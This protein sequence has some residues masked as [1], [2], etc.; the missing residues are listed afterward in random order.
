VTEATRGEREAAA[1]RLDLDRAEALERQYDS[2]MS[3]RPLPA[4]VMGVVSAGLVA[5][6]A[7]HYYTAGFGILLEHWHMAVHLAAVLAACFLVF[8]HNARAKRG[9]PGRFAFGG[10]PAF[11]W[12]LVFL[13]VGVVIYLPW[14]FDELTFRIGIPNTTDQVMGWVLVALVLE[15]TRRAMGWILPAIVV[16]FIAYGL[17]GQVL[18]GT[19]FD[20]L[21]HPGATTSN[22]IS[23][24]YLTQEGIFGIPV[25]VVSTYVFHFVLFG[26]LAMRMG[27]GQFF[28]DLSTIAAGRLA[29]GPAKVSIFGSA[30]FGMIS[31]SSL[32]NAVTVGSLT[33][34][35]MKRVGYK[36]HFAGA[37]E[38][39]A[40]AGGQITPPIM[41]AVA[42]IMVEFLQIPYT[43]IIIAAAVPAAMHY[44]GVLVQVHFEAKKTG[45]K[46]LPDSE[47]PRFWPTLRDGWPTTIPM[48]LLI[49][50]IMDGSTPYLAAFRG[51]TACLVV[52]LL[53]PNKAKRMTLSQVWV[54]F[55]VGA[56]YAL[57]VGCAAAATGVVVGVITLTGAGFRVSFM[58]TTAAANAANFVQPILALLPFHVA[59]AA[60]LKLFF[61]LVCVAFASILLGTGLPTTAV[62]ILLA[63]IT[64][65]A[66]TN[67]GVPPLAAHL[68]IF[69]YG[70]LAD[71]TPPVCVAA[72]AAA[73]IAG[74][75]PFKTGNT[76]FKLGTAKAT[77]PFVFV[78]APSML[79]VLPG[80]TWFDF[81]VS[82]MACALGIAGLGIAMTGYFLAPLG[83]LSR[84]WLTLASLLT[85]AP[86]VTSTA[87]GLAMAAPVIGL[88]LLRARGTAVPAQPR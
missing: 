77:V 29:G 69:Y 45:L 19:W 15:S 18:T 39:A 73:G 25:K 78:Y 83:M 52:G 24:V 43:Q 48:I 22:L 82:T 88:N 37:V 79:L 23:H 44:L 80:F 55:D 68:F 35:A 59:S 72:F 74:A 34:P 30:L 2:E 60:D 46:G 16:A 13:S 53:N 4:R 62:Y 47:I 33:I 14:N 28:I 17:W 58:V 87:V 56:R 6:S 1:Q 21:S 75:D 10:V 27:L 7:F 50:T 12:V 86:S 8:G 42:F 32:A 67:M 38:A 5:L 26:V 76:A 61:S 64:A 36:P 31:G 40:S 54:A 49:Y 85:I 57:A 3:F 81:A 9:D 20:V 84:W 71:L 63:A 51:I 11:D 41:G 70:I 65:P 66:L